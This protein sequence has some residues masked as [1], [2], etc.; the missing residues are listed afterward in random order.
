MNIFQ[1]TQ[2]KSL[3]ITERKSQ[4]RLAQ[5]LDAQPILVPYAARTTRQITQTNHRIITTSR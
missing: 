1:I 3:T 4:A 5:D 2:T